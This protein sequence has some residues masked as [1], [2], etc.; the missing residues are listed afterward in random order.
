M[1]PA[2]S[3]F[4]IKEVIFFAISG[5]LFIAQAF[6][7][8]RIITREFSTQPVDYILPI[9]ATVGFAVVFA[10]TA[11]LITARWL[12]WIILPSV[13]ATTVLF[14]PL[15]LGSYIATFLIALPLIYAL[16]NTSSSYA[17][18]V[19]FNSSSVIKAG[20]SG[21]FT[22]IALLMSFYYLQVQLTKPVSIIPSGLIESVVSLAQK[23][24]IILPKEITDNLTQQITS[25]VKTQ[26][27]KLIEP[28]KPF[29]PYVL[30]AL[31]FLSVRSL[32]F[33][34]T[35][36]IIPLAAIVLKLLIALGIVRK[37]VVQIEAERVFF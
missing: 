17:N 15:W 31:F 2:F 24:S 10:L 36:M 21:T 7:W 28:Y 13:A 1:P 35:W 26:I 9:M 37:E 4:T 20:L 30:T 19:N 34:L 14:I 29:V 32:T 27:D 12:G 3:K 16:Y 22:A 18:S 11:I 25:T 6:F 8:Q 33:I 23:Q 5:A